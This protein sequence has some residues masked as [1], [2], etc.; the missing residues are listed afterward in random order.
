MTDSLH[1]EVRRDDLRKTRFRE[2][3]LSEPA[4]GEALV[5]VDRFALTANNVTYAV[6]GDMLS[7]WKFFPADSGWGRVPVW[8]FAEV[9]RSSVSALREGERL[10]GYFPMSSHLV[11]RP[12]ALTPSGFV[13]AAPHRAALPPVYNQ[14]RRLAAD[15]GY[16]A[17]LADR[18]AVL[19]PLFMTG[20]LLADLLAD[21]QFCGARRVVIASAS[22][23]TSIAL[24]AVLARAG[25]AE[26]VGL[27]SARNAG[28]VEKLGCYDRVVRYDAIASL[29]AGEP[30]AFVDMAGDAA[31]L[32]AVH[33]HL[34]A[35]L[36]RS[37]GVGLTHWESGPRATDLPGAKPEFFFAPTRIQKRTQEWGARALQE[38]MGEAW[39]T[40]ARDSERWLEIEA[41][42]GRAAVERVYRDT[43]EGRARPDRGYLLSL[44]D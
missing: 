11:L 27:T 28:F 40:F 35:L 26:V 3:P 44:G 21:E 4:P 38:R 8:G 29:P 43:L 10:Y 5:R 13:D 41:G 34:G 32:A 19:Q 42:R 16:D 25:G 39:R 24:A 36:V 9:A 31:V 1:F 6:A 7:Y 2:T 12:G 14:Y 20:W 18:Q 37:I 15:P 33:R 30:A 17:A 23:K 22:S